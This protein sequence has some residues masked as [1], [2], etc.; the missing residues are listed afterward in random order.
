MRFTPMTVLDIV[1]VRTITPEL[2]LA[3]RLSAAVILGGLIGWDR[4]AKNRPAGLRTHMLTSL[5]SAAFAIVALELMQWAVKQGASADPIRA[6]EAVT[7]GVAFLAAGTIIQS[8][9][10]VTGLTTGA[11]M[12]LAGAIGVACGTGLYSVA[13]FVTLLALLILAGLQ[14]LSER[15]AGEASPNRGSTKGGR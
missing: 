6:I 8:R 5:A 10:E 13:V 11:G 7:A 1:S 9:G 2:E 3:I 15:V 12:W 14:R 4:E